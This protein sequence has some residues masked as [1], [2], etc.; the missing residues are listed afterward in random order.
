MF[1]EEIAAIGAA[2]KA[3]FT[4][5]RNNPA[6][7]FL[8]SMLAGAYVGF[9]ILLIFTAGGALAPAPWAKIVMGVSFGIALSLV[10]VAGAE[11]FTG[12]NL[13]MT[14][15][16][17]QGTVT[18]SQS[19]RLWVVCLI[20]NWA[21]SVLLAVLFWGSGLAVGAT[22]EF[23]A[24]TSAGKMAV[25]LVPLFLRGMLCNTLV[26]LAVWCGFRCKSESGKLIM[27]FWCLY[28][29]IT[30]GFEH[31]IANMTLLT[32]G[33]LSPGTAAV[34]LSG[35]FYNIIVVTLGNMAGAMLF[36]ALPYCLIAKK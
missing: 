28:A 26:C 5:L 34:S 12:N 19:A 24:A 16:I 1:G 2:A 22:A 15:G 3:K 4:F 21:G 35:Y 31:S 13:V 25:P 32:V 33:L 7:Y 11:L 14:T 8:S 30:C 36:L 18:W 10:V 20:G 23:A 6:G 27:I 17:M 9:G 29:F